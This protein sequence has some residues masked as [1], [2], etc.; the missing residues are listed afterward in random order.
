MSFTWKISSRITFKS[1]PFSSSFEEFLSNF[2]LLDRV[3]F[4]KLWYMRTQGLINHEK[5][6]FIQNV[7]ANNLSSCNF[8]RKYFQTKSSSKSSQISIL[9]HIYQKKIEKNYCYN[10]LKNF[11][12]NSSNTSYVKKNHFSHF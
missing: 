1:W 10:P 11:P 8:K 5:L 2:E 12:V 9:L 6:K 4:Y 7:N 3:G